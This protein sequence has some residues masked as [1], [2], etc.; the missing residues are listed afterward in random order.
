M[1]RTTSQVVHDDGRTLASAVDT[2]EKRALLA[3][4]TRARFEVGTPGR[5]FVVP[6]AI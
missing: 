3:I 5:S 6:R 2:P 1:S 4:L